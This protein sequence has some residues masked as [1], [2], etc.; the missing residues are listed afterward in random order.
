M[1]TGIQWSFLRYCVMACASVAHYITTQNKLIE[2][3]RSRKVIGQIKSQFRWKL[4]EM[5]LL[6]ANL[7]RNY[8]LSTIPGIYVVIRES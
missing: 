5:Q 2:R 1:S 3:C 4:R 7:T 6:A 8:P